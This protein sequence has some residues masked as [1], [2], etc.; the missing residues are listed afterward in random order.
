M[1]AF[2]AVALAGIIVVALA[3]SG[4]A[5]DDGQDEVLQPRAYSKA[6]ARKT[7]DR[8]RA[9]ALK[10]SGGVRKG[11]LSA[12]PGESA[13]EPGC[14]YSAAFNGCHDGQTGFERNPRPVRELIWDNE[15]KLHEIYRRARR[16]C[17]EH[18]RD[19][20]NRQRH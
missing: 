11:C 14:I 20:G 13:R 5:E 9:Y 2:L 16:Y 12:G 1:A 15:P 18:I 4:C 10:R 17:R 7:S 3:F 19:E 8:A 6:L